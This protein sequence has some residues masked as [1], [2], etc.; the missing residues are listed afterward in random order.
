MHRTIT[1]AL[2]GL[3]LAQPLAAQSPDTAPASPSAEAIQMTPTATASGFADWLPA[4]RTRAADAG[5]APDVLDRALAQVRFNEK[6]IDRDRNQNEFTKTIWDYLDTAVSDDRI[7]NGRKA[8]AQHDATLRR[9]E[10]DYGVD[11]HVVAAIWGL[12]SA[13]GTFRGDIPTIEALATLAYD[14]RRAMAM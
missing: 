6:I 7:A 1:A 12:E 3:A 5:L 2:A 8:M 9:I 10:A 13:Y 11:R 14:G 4:F